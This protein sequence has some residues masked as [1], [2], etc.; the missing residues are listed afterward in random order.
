MAAEALLAGLL[1]Q[2]LALSA[3]VLGVAA[4]RPL[5][6]RA[7]GARA[8]YGLWL[9]LPLTL[10]VN[11]LPWPAALPSPGL[12]PSIPPIPT[13]PPDAGG[14][15]GGALPGLPGP[16]L[17]VG[18]WL[19]GVIGML[20]RDL[21]RQRAAERRLRP[22]GRGG[23]RLPAGC[24]PALFGLWRPRLALPDD[25]T[26]GFDPAERRAIRLHEAVHRA[27]RDNA[28]NLLAHALA[29]LHW[30][31]PLAAWALRRLRQDQELACDAT[32]LQR[33]TAPPAAVYARAL[34]KVEGLQSLLPAAVAWRSTHPLV[35]RMQMLS[36]HTLASP[37]RRRWGRAA[38][39][40]LTLLSAGAGYG[41]QSTPPQT[42]GAGSVSL[43]LTL[44]EDGTPVTRPRLRGKLGEPMTV[45]WTTP[46]G[47][48]WGL[49][50]TVTTAE[51]DRLMVSSTLEHGTPPVAVA[52]P[53]L[54]VANGQPA[55]IESKP[56]GAAHKL[57]IELVARTAAP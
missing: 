36:T 15:G 10:A 44:S 35:E 31:N 49:T 18:L 5:L 27:R 23:W 45:R 19:S 32:V 26:E 8:V 39:A 55:G 20:G 50:L 56:A 41:L 53:R 37:R 11:L 57:R 6:R 1:A 51:A 38:A 4:C 14:A 29:A 46:G 34:L 42:V 17:L 33:R 22:D 3:A 52:S 24:S 43:E 40:T 54:L 48:A 30:F 7:F 21:Y 47:E 13:M 28:V 2:T 25:F 9:A 12:L 16:A